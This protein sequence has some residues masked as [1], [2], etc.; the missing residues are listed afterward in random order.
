MPEEI[1][2]FEAMYTQRAI[3]Y[4]KPYPIPDELI[5]RVVEAGTKYG[6]KMKL[7]SC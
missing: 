6:T 5:A 2:L 7:N 3:R 4:L 1:G